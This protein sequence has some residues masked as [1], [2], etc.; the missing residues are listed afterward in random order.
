[1]VPAQRENTR[2][3]GSDRKR[4]KH[5]YSQYAQYGFNIFYQSVNINLYYILFNSKNIVYEAI[6]ISEDFLF[7]LFII[8][9]FK[10]N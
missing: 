8:I 9:I 1:M 5:R 10:K 2:N 7:I 4:L 6:K 3:I